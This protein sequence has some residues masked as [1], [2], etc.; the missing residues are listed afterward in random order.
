MIEIV[1]DLVAEKSS[2][3]RSYMYVCSDWAIGGS[4]KVLLEHML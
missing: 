3:R 1:S 2:G 4:L